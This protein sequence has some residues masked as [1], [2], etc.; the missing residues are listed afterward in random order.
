MRG[1]EQTGRAQSSTARVDDGIKLTTFIPVRFVRHKARKVVV[2]PTTPGRMASRKMPGQGAVCDD[3]LMRALARGFFWQELLDSG[4]VSN[5]AEIA[6]HEG[7]EKVR[8]Q[9]MLRLA[10]LAPDV[11]EDIARGQQPVGVS[12]EL[13][14]RHPMPDDWNAQRDVIGGLV[15]TVRVGLKP[16][17]HAL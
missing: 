12:L 17:R 1:M 11:V 9:K 14:M 16:D 7:V 15:A 3:T 13:F 8:V 6:K 5:I 4:R 2:E 10:R